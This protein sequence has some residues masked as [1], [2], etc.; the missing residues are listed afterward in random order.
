MTAAADELAALSGTYRLFARL[1]MREVDDKFLAS[2]LKPPL[3][4]GFTAAGGWLPDAAAPAT[5]EE[6]AMDYCQ[7]FL[8][9]ANHLPPY[10]SVWQRGHFQSESVDSMR[11]YVAA[12][13][14]EP[15]GQM[16]DHLGVQLEVMGGLLEIGSKSV[17]HAD[18]D[19]NIV[20]TYFATHLTWSTPLLALA[21]D[22]AETDFYRSMIQ[23]TRALLE[24]E[25]AY[26]AAGYAVS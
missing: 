1:W 21:I 13:G 16:R 4:D 24:S 26:W 22:R 7:L 18:D 2:L 3:R 14:C 12:A 25:S 23:M 6:L 9:P 11:H 10:Q 8:G 20:S 15:S 5:L 17:P 19:L